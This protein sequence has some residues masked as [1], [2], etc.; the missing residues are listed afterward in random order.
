MV[1]WTYAYLFSDDAID[2]NKS[3]RVSVFFVETPSSSTRNEKIISLI[4]PSVSETKKVSRSIS[5]NQKKKLN[6]REAKRKNKLENEILLDAVEESKTEGIIRKWFNWAQKVRRLRHFVSTHENLTKKSPWRLAKDAIASISDHGKGVTRRKILCAQMFLQWTFSGR[7]CLGTNQN[8]T[9][10]L[11]WKIV[12]DRGWWREVKFQ[13]KTFAQLRYMKM[14]FNMAFQ[15]YKEH[16][17]WEFRQ[18]GKRFLWEV[19]SKGPEDGNFFKMPWKMY[20]DIKKS[21][22]DPGII[23]CV[24]GELPPL[25]D[26]NIDFTE[27]DVIV[28]QADEAA[29][30]MTE[31]LEAMLERK[32]TS[33]E[34]S[35]LE[36]ILNS[37]Q[38]SQYFH[39]GTI[40]FFFMCTFDGVFLM[41]GVGH[42][43]HSLFPF[44]S[45][46]GFGGIPDWLPRSKFPVRRS[47]TFL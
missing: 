26:E 10:A 40:K 3:V 9:Q 8:S 45:L 30:F 20:L 29:I 31:M 7:K 5:K 27:I 42:D 18:E 24:W 15:S 43:G 38:V 19:K 2:F 37:F 1:A 46:Y 22:Q 44:V 14:F 25:F 13:V 32:L 34:S 21:E 39:E 23:P 35:V 11:S 4:G 36:T 47:V 33:E 17:T 41:S 12:T 16:F 6:K 28:M